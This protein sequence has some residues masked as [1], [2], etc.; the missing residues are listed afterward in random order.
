MIELALMAIH[1]NDAYNSPGN[2]ALI[3]FA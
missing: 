3:Y 1:F 2:F